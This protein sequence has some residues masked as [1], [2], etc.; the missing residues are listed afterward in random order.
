LRQSRTHDLAGL[1]IARKLQGLGLFSRL[2]VAGER[3]RRH[4]TKRFAQGPVGALL[5]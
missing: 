3:D 5:A 1:G 4:D 2:Y